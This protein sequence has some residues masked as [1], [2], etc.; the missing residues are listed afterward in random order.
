MNSDF[1]GVTVAYAILRT[2]KLK[3]FGEIG[4]SLSHNYRNRPTPNAD[5]YRTVNKEHD[6]KTARQVMDGIK[7]RLPEKTRKNAVLAIEYL[8]TASP[9]WSG[10]GTE[11]EADFFIGV[12]AGL[13]EDE[14]VIP[15]LLIGSG[16]SPASIA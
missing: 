3:S 15:L 11:K 5:P 8:I 10:L 12:H 7:N 13:L 14:M 6:L 4:G 1:L 16:K 2:A 9:D